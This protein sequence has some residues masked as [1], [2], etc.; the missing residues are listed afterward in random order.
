MNLLRGLFGSSLGKKYIMAVTGL[1][2]AVGAIALVLP[3]AAVAPAA[4]ETPAGY[5]SLLRLVSVVSVLAP[6]IACVTFGW[7]F[8]RLRSQAVADQFR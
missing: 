1:A 4:P 3:S 7:I 6:L 5:T 2:I 8:W